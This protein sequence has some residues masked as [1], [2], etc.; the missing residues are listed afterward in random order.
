MR[1]ALS[2][3]AAAV[4][5]ASGLTSVQSVPAA[6]APPGSAFDPGL[7]ISDSVFFDFGS[8]TVKQIQDF[9]DSRVENCRADDP[10]IDCLKNVR[11]SIPETPATAPG[12]VGPCKAIAAKEQA[13]AAE[14]I[15]AIAN[16]CGINPRV[17]IVTLQKEQ[18]LVTSTKPTSY[19]YRAAMGF[20]CPDSDPAI[21]GKVFV[22][23]FNQLYRAAKQF[24]WYGNPEGSFTYWKPGRVISMRF[25]PKS[26]C[27]SKS[28]EL[29]NQ[30]TANLYYYTPYTPNEA[31]LRNLYGVGDSCS[32]YGN[33]NFWRFYHDWFGSPIGGGYLLKSATSANYLIV[34]ELRYLV[35]DPKL[36]ESLRPLG[37]LG[38]ISQAYLDSFQDA[39]VM[40]PLVIDNTTNVRYLLVDSIRYEITDCQ[41]AAHYGYDCNLAIPLTSLQL[42]NF[43]NG[44]ALTRL[45]ESATGARY[46]IENRTYRVV[47]D[48]LALSTVGGQGTQAVKL[49]VEQ[50]PALIQGAALASELA[51]FSL[52]GSNDVL[53][54]SGGQTFRFVASLATSTNL[55]RWFSS[56][57]ATVELSSIQASLNPA[58]IRGF[59]SSPQGSAFVLTADGKVPVTDPQDWTSQIVQV[60][61]T[62]LAAIPTANAQLSTP[63]VVSSQ[64]NN[65]SYFVDGSARRTS[66]QKEMTD[67]FL[68]LLNQPRVMML[69]QAAINAVSSS[70]VALSP[71]SIIRQGSNFFL[72]DGITSLIRL[73]SQAHATSVSKSK[74]FSYNQS[75][76]AGFQIRTRLNS[77]KVQ[78]AGGTYLLDKGTLYPIAQNAANEYP[79]NPY[80]LAT[81]TC[82]ALE[83]SDRPAG[84]FIRDNSGLLFLIQDG[85]KMRISS[86]AH[87]AKLRGDSP[88]H[89]EVTGYFASKI[90]SGERAPQ[91]VTLASGGT[92]PN[93]EFGE[94]TFGG[95]LP[96]NPAPTPS[97]T[98]TPTPKPTPTPTPTPTSTPTQSA[99]VTTSPVTEYRVRAGDTLI[100]IAARFAVSVSRLQSLNGISNP[101]QLRVGQLLKIP[102]TSTSSPATSSPQPTQPATQSPSVS[103][104]VRTY[105]VQAGDTLW[106]IARK[107]G[108][109]ADALAKLNG[110]TNANLIKVGQT[111]KIPS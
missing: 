2:A 58:S 103:P 89:I 83:L 107:F 32:A 1:K 35:S 88:A 15:H 70:G 41:V 59:V 85:K 50:V 23:L 102:T 90:P 87:L 9:L 5:I 49:N 27:G 100:S 92:I 48:D 31:A 62:L 93:G 64:G 101:N 39:G 38:E 66:S 34:N 109:S 61:E 20:G 17:L 10:A 21:C 63:V 80:P 78:C 84:Q 82:S 97:P 4:L 54:A 45:A 74:V 46:W 40:S 47:V 26:S 53:V 96:N 11:V 105:Q 36:L 6:A 69:P 29:K 7:I 68:N 24:R 76:L 111:L 22:G 71:G 43:I 55:Q 79:G 72:V 81:S 30:A 44:G 60:P 95:T 98:P 14:V 52:K 110:I 28:F 75:D 86:W 56:T 3:F 37:P 25:N 42:N 106:G 99:P 19:M 94:L 67:R 91:T 33:R 8:M 12:E 104:V 16:A 51:L 13:T 77:L 73:E 18:G 108:V 65:L 57:S